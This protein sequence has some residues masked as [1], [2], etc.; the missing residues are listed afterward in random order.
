V[1]MLLACMVSLICI[2]FNSFLNILLIYD[3]EEYLTF[4]PLMLVLIVFRVLANM[5]TFRKWYRLYKGTFHAG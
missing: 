5:F 3:L 2:I 1:N 4:I